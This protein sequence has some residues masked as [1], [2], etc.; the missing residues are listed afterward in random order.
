MKKFMMW[1]SHLYHGLPIP[2]RDF[3]FMKA[4]EPEISA[5]KALEAF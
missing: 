1:R 4:H 2:S 3:W 5:R